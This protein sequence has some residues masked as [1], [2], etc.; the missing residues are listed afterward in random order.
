MLL[1]YYRILLYNTFFMNNCE[2]C[3]YMATP[4]GNAV[5]ESRLTGKASQKYLCSNPEEDCLSTVQAMVYSTPFEDQTVP[6]KIDGEDTVLHATLIFRDC[7]VIDSELGED[8]TEE[9][10]PE[11]PER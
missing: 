2:T 6:I 11:S 10:P 1:A 8:T 4:I 5:Q 9:V 3:E 7:C